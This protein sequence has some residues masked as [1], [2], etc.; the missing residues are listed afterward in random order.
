MATKAIAKRRVSYKAKVKRSRRNPGFTLP[1]A[2]IGGF[3]PLLYHAYDDFQVGGLP[4][5]AKGIAA[6]TTGYMVDTGKFELNYLSGGALPILAGLIVH[7]VA[8]RLGVNRLLAQAR[9]PILRV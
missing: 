2:V 7:K 6:R 8:S 5:L 1:L 9:I 3:V 4:H